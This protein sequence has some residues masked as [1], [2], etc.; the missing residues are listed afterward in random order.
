MHSFYPKISRFEFV[1]LFLAVGLRS[2]H[3]FSAPGEPLYDLMNGPIREKL[4]IIPPSVI[5]EGCFSGSICFTRRNS[6]KVYVISIDRLI[7][8]I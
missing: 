2:G 3:R 4:G 6:L 5:W 7:S 8:R 1:I